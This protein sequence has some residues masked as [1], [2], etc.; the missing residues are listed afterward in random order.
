MTVEDRGPAAWRPQELRSLRLRDIILDSTSSSSRDTSR[1]PSYTVAG[2]WEG[3][4]V[5]VKRLLPECRQD[6][7]YQSASTWLNLRHPNIIRTLAIS[8]AFEHP[9]FV[10]QPCLE[11]GGI[12]QWI[13]RRQSADRTALIL[14]V[15]LGMQYLHSHEVIHGSLTPTNILVNSNG[16]ACVSDYDM[17]HLQSSRNREAHRYYS[18]EAWRG[19]NLVLK[20]SSQV[21]SSSLPWGILSEK[22]IYR[23]VVQDGFRPDRP[24][25][26]IH[27]KH[28]LDDRVWSL[29]EKAWHQEP[30]RRPAFDIILRMLQGHSVEGHS[31]NGEGT[32]RPK[33]SAGSNENANSSQNSSLTRHRVGGSSVGSSSYATCP[34]AYAQSAAS[35]VQEEPEPSP[36]YSD[37]TRVTGTPNPPGAPLSSG[38]L[39][40]ELTALVA[41]RT[42]TSQSRQMTSTPEWST[43]V[44]ISRPPTSARR[45]A[46]T[47]NNTEY[48]T[49][50]SG[51]R[52]PSSPNRLTLGAFS[53]TAAH[54]YFHE[55]TGR[56]SSRPIP[57]SAPATRQEFSIDDITPPPSVRTSR[58]SG[59]S[60]SF[61][62]DL[63][64]ALPDV[65]RPRSRSM[66][67]GEETQARSLEPWTT[68][69][70]I[71]TS[72]GHSTVMWSLEPD[73]GQPT[74]TLSAV[75]RP[76]PRLLVQALQTEVKQGRRKESMDGYLIKMYEGALESDKEAFKLVAAGAVPLLIHLLKTR[77]ADDY[78][79]ELVLITLGTLAHDSISANTI[80]R[81]GTAVTIIELAAS[82]PTNE[83]ETLAIWCL[84]RICRSP[85]AAQ[86]LVKQDLT[87]IL[88]RASLRTDP[89][90][91]NMALYCLGTLIQSDALADFM[92]SAGLVPVIAGHLRL[93]AAPL[94]PNSEGLCSGLY[95]LSRLSR[96]IKIAKALANA[97]CVELL[98]YQLRHSNN[99]EVLHWAARAAGCLMRPNSNDMAKLLLDAGVAR[100][101]AR[102]PTVLPPDVVHPLGSFGFTIQRFSCAQW[103]S[104][105]RKAL[106]EAGVT[107]AL[108]AALRVVADEQCPEVH[109]ELALAVSLLGDVGGAAIRKE[110]I[111]AGGIDILRTVGTNASSEVS[112]ACTMA[113]TS[114]TGNVFSGN[115]DDNTTWDLVKD[116]EKLRGHLKIEKWHVFGGSW[117][118]AS[119]LFPEAWDE[120][121][122]PIPE[123]ERQDLI[124]AYHAQLNS[125]DEATRVTAAKAW[126]KWEMTTSKLI[127][128]PEFVRRAESDKF[129]NYEI[130]GNKDGNPV[131]LQAGKHFVGG[132]GGGCDEKDRSFFNPHKYKI[133]LLDQRGAGKSTPSPCI[134]DNTT[135]DLVKDIEKLRGH[136]KIEKW[137]VFGGS[138]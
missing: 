7:L 40:E 52:A 31:R 13:A 99:P 56:S 109:V 10:V 47:P 97:G 9:S 74:S 3:R 91:R 101:L 32:S 11:N 72:E 66:L 106:V 4:K 89:M 20:C 68:P 82:P 90:I 58:S 28:G 129:S 18:P 134:D 24:T 121:V 21:F 78:G 33:G 19:A 27:Y 54:Q 59:S 119:H 92:A 105:T 111:K 79:V 113:I 67:M 115:A 116:V 14:D 128:D 71:G 41:A 135:W 8:S 23:L 126:T 25:D 34:P 57:Q 36:E 30:Q 98:A 15:A 127:V 107:D 80:H 44:G 132:P 138:W 76:S 53:A 43:T 86:G 39:V 12:T 42:H 110:I 131:K 103:G 120:Y 122:A 83:I 95:A 61:E 38:A 62:S 5:L 46:I 81:T 96:S 112:K 16:R 6:A 65:S 69:E 26:E 85:E 123:A 136:L 137:H 125:V 22:R 49:A 1:R 55:D 75:A 130:S 124:L 77:A 84:N 2:T 48:T 88:F 17:L 133:I 100:G 104:A 114:V 51:S 37:Y 87:P 93:A 50:G 70:G 45:L 108:L 64:R 60:P 94:V 118:G 29:I 102:L 73:S 35:Q 117:E 63:R